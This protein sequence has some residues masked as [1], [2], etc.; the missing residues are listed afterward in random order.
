MCAA[1][2]SPSLA[3]ARMCLRRSPVRLPELLFV[4]ATFSS[5]QPPNSTARKLT[6]CAT[7]SSSA[8]QQNRLDRLKHDNRVECQALVLDVV[9]LVL[10]LLPRVFDRRAVRIFDLRPAGQARRDQMSL[11]VIRNFLRQLRH[12]MRAL[13]TRADKAHVAAQDVPELR[14]L[15]HA[16]LAYEATHARHAIVF[17]LRP[18]GAVFL[19]VAAHR[20]KLHQREHAAVAAHA[21]LSVKDWSARIEFDQN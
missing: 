7:S 14:D 9:K 10:Q 3:T 18:D 21:L 1:G 2:A 6:T 13:R 11:F 20:T 17:C 8:A 16:N 19:G 5:L 4:S 12:E 15:V